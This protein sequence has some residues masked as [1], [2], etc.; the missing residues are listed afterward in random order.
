MLINNPYPSSEQ[1]ENTPPE[2]HIMVIPYGHSHPSMDIYTTLIEEGLGIYIRVLIY[3][4]L[5]LVITLQD[6]HHL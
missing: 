3:M 1:P 2:T 5:R 6:A 4:L